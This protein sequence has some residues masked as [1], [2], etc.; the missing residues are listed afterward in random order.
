[1]KVH[2]QKKKKKKKKITSSFSYKL[3][4]VNDKFSQP[5]VVFRGRNDAYKIIE[6]I[7]KEH[8]YCKRLMKKHFKKKLI[9][10]EEEEKQFQSS[11]NVL[12]L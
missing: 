7:L 10:T 1:M 12:D 4:W 11:K 9:M 5:I 6:A 8:E 3:V 2:I